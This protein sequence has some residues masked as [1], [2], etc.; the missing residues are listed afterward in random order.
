MRPS[1]FVY[2]DLPYD[3]RISASL[4][5]RH[6]SRNH[7]SF[8]TSSHPGRYI[9]MLRYVLRLSLS[10]QP[11]V[12]V[13]CFSLAEKIFGITRALIP[14]DG[15][16]E[17]PRVAGGLLSLASMIVLGVSRYC[18]FVKGTP[19]EVKDLLLEV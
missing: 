4:P 8:L 2:S 5:S 7:V 16:M 12:Y 10:R 9:L 1:V 18:Y 11:F 19:S 3:V 14:H 6:G 17:A 13:P 15:L